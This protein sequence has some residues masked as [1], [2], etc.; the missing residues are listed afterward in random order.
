MRPVEGTEVGIPTSA[1]SR[2]LSTGA[3]PE[4]D[5]HAGRRV[6]IGPEKARFV[7]TYG[8]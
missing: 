7:K 6:L 8:N 2:W 5:N 1:G 4:W 3:S